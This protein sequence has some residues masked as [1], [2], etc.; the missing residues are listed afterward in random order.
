M[1]HFASTT[2]KFLA[3]GGL[4]FSLAGFGVFAGTGTAVADGTAPDTGSYDEQL[5]L[6][7]EDCWT[8]G[9]SAG[10][11]HSRINAS[12]PANSSWPGGNAK[13]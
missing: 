13:P 12:Y 1:K 4:A 10:C 8:S 3:A 9:M 11:E 5:D 6:A 2:K 7:L